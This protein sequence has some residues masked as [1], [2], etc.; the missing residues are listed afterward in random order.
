MQETKNSAKEM[1]AIVFRLKNE[2]YGVDVQQVRSIE[3]LEHITRVPNAPDFIKG[4]INL[5]G[6]V[7]PVIDLRKRFGMEQA[8]YTDQ[9]RIIIVKMG[10]IEVGLIV[11]AANDVIDIPLDQVEATPEIVGGVE[12]EYLTGVAKLGSRLLILLNLEKVLMINEVE[13]LEKLEG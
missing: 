1:K 11:D 13:Q 5:R 4:V 7:T 8:A 3:R 10:E 2:E 12:A 9:N 6:V